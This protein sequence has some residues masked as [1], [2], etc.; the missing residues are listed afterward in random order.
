MRKKSAKQQ[1]AVC[2]RWSQ[3]Q[4]RAALQTS[5]T[6]LMDEVSHTH[7]QYEKT[8]ISI[9]HTWAEHNESLSYNNV[10]LLFPGHPPFFCF[11]VFFFGVRAVCALLQHIDICFQCAL[12]SF[13]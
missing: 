7:L 2:V 9:K 11:F 3:Y 8:T 6:D 4:G 1:M 5:V 12:L 10:F 13:H